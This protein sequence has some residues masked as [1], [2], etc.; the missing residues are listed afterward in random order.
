MRL[1]STCMVTNESLTSTHGRSHCDLRPL[2]RS[3]KGHSVSIMTLLITKWRKNGRKMTNV[4]TLGKTFE[5]YPPVAYI[6]GW[7]AELFMGRDLCRKEATLVVSC[8]ELIVYIWLFHDNIPSSDVCPFPLCWSTL[9]RAAGS[10]CHWENISESL[11]STWKC[12]CSL[13]L[14]SSKRTSCVSFVRDCRDILEVSE[15][16]RRMRFPEEEFNLLLR[17]VEKVVL[18]VKLQWGEVKKNKFLENFFGVRPKLKPWNN[19]NNNN[20]KNR[21]KSYF[22]CC[23]I[24][25]IQEMRIFLDFHHLLFSF[26]KKKHLFVWKSSV[27][28]RWNSFTVLK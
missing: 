19:N 2:L 15:N 4:D 24:V 5:G 18:E 16:Q 1:W 11:V 6:I 20:K 28:I 22:F 9:P 17:V 23:V 13:K 25:H 10:L 3:L 26:R 8:W 21:F 27:V 12:S 14:Q 7:A